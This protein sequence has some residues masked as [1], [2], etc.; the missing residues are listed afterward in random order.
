[1]NID[2]LVS[3]LSA[4]KQELAIALCQEFVEGC[5]IGPDARGIWLCGPDGHSQVRMNLYDIFTDDVH[6][7]GEFSGEEADIM[8]S[9][10]E[11]I[12]KFLRG[13]G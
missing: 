3:S 4:H 11:R 8:I 10:F 2:A 9:E 13:D 7:A 1:M 6:G 12:I 5:V